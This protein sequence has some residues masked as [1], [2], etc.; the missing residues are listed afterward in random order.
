MDRL[1]FQDEITEHLKSLLSLNLDLLRPRWADLLT[2]AGSKEGAIPVI[3]TDLQDQLP[4]G[5]PH[6]EIVFKDVS[7]LQYAIGT[8]HQEFHYD[9]I[10]TVQNNHPEFAKKLLLILAMSIQ[11]ILNL[12]ENRSFCIPNQK[13]KVYDSYCASM[14]LGFRRGK[15]LRSAKFDFWAKMLL[16]DRF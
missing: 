11:N 4:T 3:W 16:P 5:P 9:I 12:Y 14:D 7:N 13:Y 1:I 15:G 6:V 10:V 2:E 8:Q